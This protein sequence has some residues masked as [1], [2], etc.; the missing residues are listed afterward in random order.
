M[1]RAENP[2]GTFHALAFHSPTAYF[3]CRRQ[4]SLRSR[5]SLLRSFLN[6]YRDRNRHTN[7]GVVTRADETHHFDV[8]RDGGRACELSVAVHTTHGVGHAVGS[9]ASRHVIGVQGSA[10]AAARSNG[11]ILL[12]V[13]VAP[14]LV[15][16]CN[17][18][19]EASRVGGVTGDG[20]ADV[21]KAHDCHAFGN[22]VRA[23]ALDSGARTV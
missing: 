7:H 23:V 2:H 5:K 8:S 18:V 4:I 9:R 12:A 19:L 1:C 15:G 11:E 20:N 22:V 21:L 3:I 17:G 13:L 16:A 6:R 14:L 10:R